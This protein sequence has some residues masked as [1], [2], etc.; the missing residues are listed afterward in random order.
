MEKDSLGDL[1][2]RAALKSLFPRERAGRFFDAL[3]G[4]PSEGA[5]DIG[6]E[7]KGHNRDNLLFEFHLSQ[8]PGKCLA[9]NLTL[10]LPEVFSRHPVINV[11]GL[12]KEI[13]K[14]LDGRARCVGWKLGYTREV[15]D[16][17]HVIPLTVSLQD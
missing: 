3:F 11:K 4:D 8:R 14:L 13:D 5:Y 16:T 2:N 1:F 7:F 17:L 10:G 9:C 12:I 15:S 6:L